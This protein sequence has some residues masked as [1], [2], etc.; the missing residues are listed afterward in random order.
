MYIFDSLARVQVENQISGS[1]KFQHE[2]FRVDEIMPVVPTGEG[3]HLWLHIEKS[4]CNTEWV[5]RQLARLCGV[6]IMA[7]GYAGLK[8]RHGITC[9]WFS[10]HL[11]GKADP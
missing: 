10:I 3:E 11:P 5:A 4:G 8:D 9:Q 1:I 2:D 6:K 7:V